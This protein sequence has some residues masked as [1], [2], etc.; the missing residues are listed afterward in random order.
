M[1]FMVFL[2]LNPIIGNA[3]SKSKKLLVWLGDISFSIYL[4]HS[5]VIRIL[6]GNIGITSFG[7][8]LLLMLVITIVISGITFR[9]IEQ[10]FI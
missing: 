7:I 10:P 8:C 2:F 4:V 1:L 3:K 5:V 6:V 9:Y